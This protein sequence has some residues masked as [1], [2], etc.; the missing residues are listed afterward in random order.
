MAEAA[1]PRRLRQLVD[2]MLTVSS[3]LDLHSV[4][5]HIVEA[6]RDLVDAQY[7]ALG[8]LDE[9]GRWLSDFIT[10]GIDD[11]TRHVIG[12]LPKGHGILGVLITDAQPLRLP[13][14]REH[15]DSYG[16][17]PGH[18][19]M[20]SFLGV[21]VRVGDVVFGNLYL[22]DKITDEVFTDID[23][24]LVVGLAAAAGIAIDKARSH[25]QLQ[26]L[27]LLDDQERM[28]RDL[29]D[30]V[31]QRV[32]GVGLTLQGT[33]HLVRVDPDTA[34]S[35][36]D[37]AIEELD[38]TIKHLRS[39]IFGLDMRAHGATAEFRSRVLELAAESTSALG[40]EPTVF[41][42]GPIDAHIDGNLANE[43]AAVI[44]EALSN[45]ARHANA[46]RVEVHLIVTDTILLR[47]EDDGIGPPRADA[48]RGNGLN[49]MTT[50]AERLD[51]TFTMRPG[52]ESGT[53]IELSIP[54]DR[55]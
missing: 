40:F 46:H 55:D 43:L 36:I 16:F 3:D 5:Q 6:A 35:R 39:A 19:P 25:S 32:F 45:T 17:P 9:S 1:G 33:R 22:T 52:P 48:P 23:E 49:N 12:A 37:A 42:D 28:G 27:A 13:D 31:I 54:V 8:V 2:A 44:T 11:E 21:P 24:E 51:G 4:L 20:R 34:I 38:L 10:V 41:F 15:P 50:R 53:V 47:I 30:S 18:P 29:H 7:A 14:L 26:R